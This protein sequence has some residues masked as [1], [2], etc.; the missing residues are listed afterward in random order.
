M[1]PRFSRPRLHRA[2]GAAAVAAVAAVLAAAST[3]VPAAGAASATTATST[4]APATGVANHGSAAG[5]RFFVPPPSSGAP[6]QIAQLL[7]SG[8]RKDAA[9]VA[10][11]EATPRAVWFTSGTPAQVT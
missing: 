1:S 2:S 11:M 6:Q 9:L 7:T 8:D 3:L 10:E 4:T 5:P